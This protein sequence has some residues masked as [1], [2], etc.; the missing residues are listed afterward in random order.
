M[1]SEL[2]IKK[3]NY[4]LVKLKLNRYHQLLNI[5]TE[6]DAIIRDES[7]VMFEQG[8]RTVLYPKNKIENEIIER[9]ENSNKVLEE[10][11]DYC[12]RLQKTIIEILKLTPKEFQKQQDERLK[13]ASFGDY[14]LEHK[15]IAHGFDK[16]RYM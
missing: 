4:G 15:S 8:N 3:E 16:K 7:I 5:E 6:Y 11:N 10:N 1:K 9:I 13:Y 14:T 2:N 12:R